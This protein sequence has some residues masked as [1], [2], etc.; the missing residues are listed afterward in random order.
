MICDTNA[1][2]TRLWHERYLGAAS[3][4]VDAIA[5]RR[6]PDLYLL[7][8]DDIPFVQDGLRD[9][10]HIRHTMHRRFVEELENQSVPYA[11][12]SGTHEARMAVAVELIDGLLGEDG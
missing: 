12:L 5:A 11:L 3:P 10:E 6:P 1:W 8:D 2:A 4:E 7:T 9:G